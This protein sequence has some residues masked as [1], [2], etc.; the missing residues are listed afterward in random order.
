[1]QGNERKL[2]FIFFHFLF[3]NGT[4]QWV[5][6]D[7]N[8]KISSLSIFPNYAT[9]STFHQSFQ[10][11]LS[12]EGTDEGKLYHKFSFSAIRRGVYLLPGRLARTR[13]LPDGCAPIYMTTYSGGGAHEETW[14]RASRGGTRQSRARGRSPDDEGAGRQAG[15]TAVFQQPLE[16][17]QVLRQGLSAEHRP[18][19]ALWHARWRL[20]LRAMGDARRQVR[21]Q[22]QLRHPKKQRRHALVMVAERPQPLDHRRQP[23]AKNRRRLGDRRRRRSRVQSLFASPGQRAEVASR[24]Q[25]LH[26][27]FPEDCV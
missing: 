7:S 13:P 1:M 10:S 12:R 20:W 23:V 27:G 19:H 18:A 22:A 25:S 6:G 11:Y 9:K 15:Q 8:K 17:S 14:D 4:F 5:T 16:L 3:R 24:Q 2:A 26:H 21:G